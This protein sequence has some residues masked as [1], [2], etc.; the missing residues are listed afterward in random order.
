MNHT[1]PYNP[2]TE[3]S[4]AEKPFAFLSAYTAFHLEKKHIARLLTKLL[5]VLQMR[6]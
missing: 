4:L 1:E 6:S 2:E 3:Q 5:H